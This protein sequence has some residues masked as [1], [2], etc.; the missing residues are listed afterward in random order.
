[1]L[2]LGVFGFGVAMFRVSP[3]AL[4][5]D[6]PKAT[7]SALSQEAKILLKEAASDPSG[8]VLFERFGEGVDLH[9]NGK[10]LLT[11]KEDHRALAQWEF[12]LEELVKDG[13]LVN[14][15]DRGEVYEITPKGY[16]AAEHIR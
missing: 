15:G 9:T 2:F 7:I 14:R 16:E 4:M 5:P 1:M 10:S 11:S 12:S 3:N 8:L 6:Q 13:L